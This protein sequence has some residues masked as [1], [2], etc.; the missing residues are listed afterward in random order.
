MRVNNVFKMVKEFSQSVAENIGSYVYCLIDPIKNEIFYIGKGKGN[1]VFNHL[2]EALKTSKE[3]DKLAQIREIRDKG[4]EPE[5]FILRYSLTDEEAERI[6]AVLIDFARLNGTNNF[7]LKNL[8]KGSGSN[9]YGIRTV[10]DIYHE[11]GAKEI[12]IEEPSL[13]I[14]INRHY[15]K[16][17]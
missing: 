8:V 14:V 4:K 3:S 2:N 5:H 13:V 15:C 11:Y 6:E 10:D 17:W 7:N 12:E 1:R 16:R 9:Q